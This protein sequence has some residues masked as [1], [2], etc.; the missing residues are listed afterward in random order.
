MTIYERQYYNTKHL[1]CRTARTKIKLRCAACELLKRNTKHSRS[2]PCPR[3]LWHH[4]HQ[5]SNYN[6]I[7]DPKKED[8]IDALEE[9]CLVLQNGGS[10]K[11]TI[12]NKLGM[13][14]YG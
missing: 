13:I 6:L 3:T 11:D 1:I 2:F 4:I 10:L 9:I 14:V 12:G 7:S 8:A 5:C